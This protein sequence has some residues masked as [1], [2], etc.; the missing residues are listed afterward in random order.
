MEYLS[1]IPRVMMAT[2]YLWNERLIFTSEKV[3]A[4]EEVFASTAE[5]C[6]ISLVMELWDCRHLLCF[7]HLLTLLF[8]SLTLTCRNPSKWPS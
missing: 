5:L 1:T 4:A 3:P 6:S 2:F 8:V 7:M